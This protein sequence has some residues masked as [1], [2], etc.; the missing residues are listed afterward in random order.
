M[1]LS[2]GQEL[3]L[4]ESSKYQALFLWDTLKLPRRYGPE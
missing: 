4:E 1:G 2:E 3:G